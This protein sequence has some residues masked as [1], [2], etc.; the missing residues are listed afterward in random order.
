MAID[1]AFREQG[2]EFAL[3][4]SEVRFISDGGGAPDAVDP[5]TG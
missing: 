4:K 5:A 2:I 3:P 1:Q